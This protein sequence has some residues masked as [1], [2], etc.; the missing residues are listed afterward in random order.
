MISS[1][2]CGGKRSLRNGLAAAAAAA[3]AAADDDNDSADSKLWLDDVPLGDD[4]LLKFK[5]PD[6]ELPC[7]IPQINNYH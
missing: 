7:N 5:T 3:A 4:E 1:T 6:D 2:I